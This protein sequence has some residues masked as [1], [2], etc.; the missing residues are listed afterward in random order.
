V[1]ELT[2]GTATALLDRSLGDLI[3][4]ILDLLDLDTNT[5]LG[6]T[7]VLTGA[8][9]LLVLDLR[10]ASSSLAGYRE[11]EFETCQSGNGRSGGEGD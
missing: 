3:V 5:L 2:L 10:L 4:G 8:A 1:R 9:L 7:V 11:R 6:R